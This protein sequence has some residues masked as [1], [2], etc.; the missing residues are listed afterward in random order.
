MTDVRR[1]T[2]GNHV[3]FKMLYITFFRL[4]HIST[5]SLNNI[6]SPCPST[7]YSVLYL[8]YCKLCVHHVALSGSRSERTDRHKTLTDSISNEEIEA[9]LAIRDGD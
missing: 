9:I 1:I 4:F 6:N 7:L 8:Q 3:L 5:S 2:N